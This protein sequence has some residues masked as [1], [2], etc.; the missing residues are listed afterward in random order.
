[1]S[2]QLSEKDIQV[3]QYIKN[4][5]GFTK[6]ALIN[7][8]KGKYSRVTIFNALK[9]LQEQKIINV[10]KD[11]HNSQIHHL[12]INNHNLIAS[13]L[14]EI[15]EFEKVF[16]PLLERI[17]EEVSKFFPTISNQLE[18]H[19]DVQEAETIEDF[20]RIAEG[21][22]FKKTIEP[23]VL[24]LVMF[25]ECIRVFRQLLQA[26][27]IRSTS[28]WPFEI[29]D[30]KKLD[31]MNSILFHELVDI[32]LKMSNII[33]ETSLLDASQPIRS[34]IVRVM[35]ETLGGWDDLEQTLKYFKNFGLE[36]EAE[37]VVNSL[38]NIRNEIQ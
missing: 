10:E 37:P 31:Q 9:N 20:K 17:K 22:E 28:I 38:W 8:L 27:I 7:G 29:K 14:Y 33:S 19:N 21:S 36:K 18:F 3:L 13:Q 23:Y 6:E 25:V 30:R 11:N 2:E 32:Q 15:G 34:D 12:S 26:Y 35:Y 1:M 24:R 16:I 5:P 4:N